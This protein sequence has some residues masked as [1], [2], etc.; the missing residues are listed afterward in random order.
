MKN[1]ILI[2]LGSSRGDGNTR[3]M[4][5]FLLKKLPADF[6]DL[7][8]YEFGYYD[9]NN[10]N[11][12]DDFLDLSDRMIQYNRIIFCTP[13]YWYAMSGRMK[14]FF[15]CFTDLITSRKDLGRALMGKSTYLICTGSSAMIPESFELPFR[16]TS[17]YLDMSFKGTLYVSAKEIEKTNIN[18]NEFLNLFE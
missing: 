3:M 11:T 10:K 16:E 15:D 14:S 13:V 17:T 5:D 18:S 12:D 7:N 2:I 6:M 9:Y 8:Q 1:D 4:V